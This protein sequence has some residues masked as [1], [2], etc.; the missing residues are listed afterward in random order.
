MEKTL[1]IQGLRTRVGEDDAKLISDKTFD[2]IA[3]E[4][5]SSFADD[6]KITDDTWKVPVAL[7]KQFAG[8]KRHDEAEFAQKFKTDY[9]TQHEKDVEERLKKAAEE[10][11]ENFKKEHPELNGGKKEDKVDEKDLDTKIAAAVAEAMKGLTAE[12]GVIGKSLKTITDFTARQTERDKQAKLSVVR[13]Q[14][15]KHLVSLKA[16]EEAC[17]DDALDDLDYGDDPNFA[18]LKQKCI[19]A[20]EKRY[21]RY[22]GNGTQPFGGNGSGEGPGGKDS[23]FV[24]ERIAALKKVAEEQQNYAKELE[25]GFK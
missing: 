1:L 7:L 3:T 25:A 8:Q 11:V 6:D 10:A 19:D 5:L 17:I 13:D 18:D 12:D 15:K 16:N 24:K 9:A 21:K 14:L 20:Y 4:V 23:S 22:Y 2:G